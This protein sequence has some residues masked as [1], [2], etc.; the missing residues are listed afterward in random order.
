MKIIITGAH[1]TPAQAVIEEL[2]NSPETEIV[3][4]GRKYT[5]EGDN[6]PSVES[7]VLP[8]LGV[9]FYSISAGRIRRQAPDLQSFVALLKIPL[10]FIQ[11]FLIVW[12]E[13]PDVVLS[14]GGYVGVPVVISAWLLS[15]PVL[16][17]EQ[18]LVSGLA[19]RV[20][21]FFAKK[22]AVSYDTSYTFSKEKIIVTGNPLRK[23]LIDNSLS[24]K[25]ISDFL[26][27]RKKINNL[28]V[29]YVTGGNQGSHII[30]QAVLEILDKLTSQ[31]IVIHQT[32]DSKFNDYESLDKKKTEVKN[33]EN[34][35]V[36]KWFV[37][38][39]VATILKN[40]DL[41]VSRA[42][43]NTLLELSYFGIPTLLIPIPYLFADEQN[44]N[45]K[46]FQKLGLAE[47]LPQS[48][49]N[50]ESLSK[51]TSEMLDDLKELKSKALENKKN[52]ITDAA[53]RIAVETVVLNYKSD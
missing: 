46:Y 18:T 5:R 28:P 33:P 32:G 53:K 41:A 27:S 49:L 34:Y 30:N 48:E 25:E 43:A 17:H 24:S 40:A 44:K 11:S 45:A 8:E 36:K 20:S 37:T 39:E 2:K 50:A 12:R 51:K 19:N 10:G 52:I 7:T 31:A 1:F 22:I 23:E 3:Y 13:N 14:F 6:T 4:I 26:K 35:L 42:G 21:G 29:I 47:I 38:T 15:K 16:L 9:K